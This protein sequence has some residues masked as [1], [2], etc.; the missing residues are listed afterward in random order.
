MNPALLVPS[1][2]WREHPAV[3]WKYAPSG[4]PWSSRWAG[5]GS[6]RHTCLWSFSFTQG[7]SQSDTTMPGERRWHRRYR[8]RCQ[9]RLA[10]SITLADAA[11]VNLATGIVWPITILTLLAPPATMLWGWLDKRRLPL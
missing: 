3:E 5:H 6:F 1:M 9:L 11:I 7:W 8:T 2:H 10:M 4:Y